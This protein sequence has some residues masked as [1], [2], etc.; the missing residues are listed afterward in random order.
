M[1]LAPQDVP[2]A[3]IHAHA[4]LDST[5]RI[6]IVTNPT[7]EIRLELL[8]TSS[9]TLPF[10][11]MDI[12]GDGTVLFDPL[13]AH[14]ILF[15][16]I[17]NDTV[18]RQARFA[19]SGRPY[20]RRDVVGNVVLPMDMIARSPEGH[21]RTKLVVEGWDDVVAVEVHYHW[22][23]VR[24]LRP[25]GQADHT[26]MPKQMWSAHVVSRARPTTMACRTTTVRFRDCVSGTASSKL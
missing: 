11:H 20:L 22:N 18:L 4:T 14:Q 25:S 13:P 24:L 5:R 15:L 1:C 7:P 12:I 19:W 21:F 10:L 9:L 2:T 23:E 17:W 6:S 26:L 8:D 3:D 16:L